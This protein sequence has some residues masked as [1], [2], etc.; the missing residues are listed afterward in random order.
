MILSPPCGSTLTKDTVI[1]CKPPLT[2]ALTRI[3][4][5]KSER[6]KSSLLNARKKN[7]YHGSS[8]DY[9][10]IRPKNVN[11]TAWPSLDVSD[12]YEEEER[13]DLNLSERADIHSFLSPTQDVQLGMTTVA[14]PKAT[15]LSKGFHRWPRQRQVNPKFSTRKQTAPRLIAR[16]PAGTKAFS[17]QPILEQANK[18]SSNFTVS[19]QKISISCVLGGFLGTSLACL[20]SGLAMLWLLWSLQKLKG[21][22]RMNGTELPDSEIEGKNYF[23]ENTWRSS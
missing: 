1:E 16:P 8:R 19:S 2:K 17:E 9:G 22:Y 7:G 13:E 12:I 21:W 3:K 10:S 5:K 18:V 23:T 6:K 15:F 4:R 11:G 20:L 14:P